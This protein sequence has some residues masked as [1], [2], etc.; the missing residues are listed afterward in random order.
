M[1]IDI[2]GGGPGGLYLAILLKRDDPR[3]RV[4]LFEQNPAGATY[5]WGVVF[6]DLALGFLQE[7]AADVYADVAPHLESWSDQAIVHRGETVRIDGLGL[8]GVARLALLEVLRA[9]AARRGVELVLAT[10]VDD[11]AALGDADLLVGAD[12]VNS[13]VRARW[14]EAFQPTDRALGNR[15]IWYGTRRRFDCMTLTFRESPHGVF[16]AHHYR[17]AP[18]ASTFIVEC[19]AATWARAGLGARSAEESRRL[20]EAVFVETLGGEPLLVDRSQ[21]LQFRVVRA[22]HWH[23]DRVVLIGDALRTV[24]FS[25]GSG[26]RTAMEDAIALARALEGAGRGEVPAALA[27]FE[28]ERRPG[29]ERLLAVAADSAAWYERFAEAMRGPP[30]T[31]AHDYLTRSGHITPERLRARSPAFAARWEAHCAGQE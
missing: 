31:L 17:Y 7:S 25:I 27:R 29:A 13:A 30:L 18:R 5:G 10:R 16:V 19:D 15:Y 22:A 8:S 21:W 2:V 24:H 11:P 20:C 6:S 28:A 9:H 23:H 3:R 26:T 14:W 12:G 4:R 1:R